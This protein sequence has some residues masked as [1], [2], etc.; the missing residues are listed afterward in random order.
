MD[1][2]SDRLAVDDLV[3]RLRECAEADEKHA[4]HTHMAEAAETYA[5]R[6][7]FAILGAVLVVIGAVV[8]IVA[9]L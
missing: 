6:W 2:S 5:V 4:V 7:A 8:T 3:Q 9:I 1:T